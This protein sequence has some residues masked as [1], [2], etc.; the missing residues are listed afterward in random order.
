MLEDAAKKIIADGS[1][2]LRV[3]RS[4]MLQF[5]V[6]KIKKVPAGKD[7]FFVELFL[8]RVIDMS[9]LQRVANETG[10]PVEAENGRAFPT[11]LGANDFMDL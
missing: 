6:F 2:R 10:L 4:G 11:G 5:Q 9:E 1:V 8:D 3:R 7:G